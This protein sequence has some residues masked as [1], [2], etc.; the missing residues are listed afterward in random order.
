[1]SENAFKNFINY[2]SSNGI[3]IVEGFD[4]E[5]SFFDIDEHVK[6]MG[7]FHRITK[8]YNFHVSKCIDNNL[9]KVIEQYKVEIK[10]LNRYMQEQDE[11]DVSENIKWVLNRA[12]SSVTRAIESSY[13]ELIKRSMESQEI[14][15]GN[16][17]PSNIRRNNGIE[18]ISLD[19]CS[20]DM[21]EMDGV[22]FF[23]KLMKKGYRLDWQKEIEFYCKEE[24]LG[25]D[26]E[27]YMLALLSFPRESIKCINNYRLSKKDWSIDQLK[28]HLKKAIIKDDQNLI[29]EVKQ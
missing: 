9:G 8:G 17:L 4:Y 10:K 14:C 18:V 24:D 11:S 16:S 15:I 23:S 2:L 3:I 5:C 22:Y 21:V 12:Q 20:F 29:Q 28:R 27:K 25:I 1:M 19:D 6:L 7:E 26:S 13:L